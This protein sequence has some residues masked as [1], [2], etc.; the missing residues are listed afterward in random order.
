MA[1]STPP[2]NK[3][4]DLIEGLSLA[5]LVSGEGA[6]F[7]ID[8]D[9]LPHSN[10]A[11][12]YEDADILL[13][14]L[15]PEC[16]DIIDEDMYEGGEPFGKVA[17]QMANVLPDGKIKKRILREGYGSVLPEKGSVTIHYNAYFEYNDEP[18]DSTYLRKQPLNFVLNQGYVLPGLDYAVSTMKL[19]EKSQF[20]IHFDYAYG[21]LGCAPRIPPEATVLFEIEIKN[22]VD[23]GACLTYA[24]L[25]E[26]KQKYF[27]EVY[28]YCIALC[29]NAKELYKKD[30]I[31][32]AIKRY[33]IGV[34]KLETCTLKDYASQEKQQELLHLFY[35]NLVIAYT[36]IKKPRRACG[37][38]NKLSR[39]CKGACLKIPTKV[40]FQHA[41][42]LMLL[43]DYDF[44][45]RQ[46]RQA[47]RLEPQN[48]DIT[49]EFINLDLK[50]K[51][52]LNCEKSLA[53][54]IFNNTKINREPHEVDEIAEEF[55]N[56]LTSYCKDLINDAN[57]TRY[58]L[59]NEL[60]NTAIQYVKS[61]VV[62]HGLKFE[63]TKDGATE[64]YFISKVSEMSSFFDF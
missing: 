53:Q 7:E 39:I 33:N 44:A 56:L 9:N 59:P 32:Q 58:S 36:K 62:K 51:E 43:G 45:E 29:D 20:L 5:D 35:R 40:Y 61:E 12:T 24:E 31:K 1:S 63:V 2:E 3:L 26:E 11:N 52:S 50:R 60:T 30:M 47:Q 19:N 6:T 8:F 55:K 23:S 13:E 38:F 15:N 41:R 46:L 34:S 25:D 16:C 42:S 21:K 49:R 17:M 64:K 22:C 48:N 28:K 10:E 37:N 4:V 18:F 27:D 54:A 57:N 14:H